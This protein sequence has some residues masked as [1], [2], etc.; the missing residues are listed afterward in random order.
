MN[1]I[2]V[3]DQLPEDRV[4]ILVFNGD[5][6]SVT[7]YLSEFYSNYGYH[8]WSHMDEQYDYSKVTHWMPLPDR[9]TVMRDKDGE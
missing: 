5:A 7:I 2:R 9:P 4:E 1:W 6:C 3:E 8:Q